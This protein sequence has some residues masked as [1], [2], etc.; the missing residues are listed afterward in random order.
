MLRTNGDADSDTAKMLCREAIEAAGDGILFI[1]DLQW[2]SDRAQ[3]AL[4]ELLP[5]CRGRIISAATADLLLAVERGQ[6]LDR[7]FYRLNILHFR[8]D[9]VSFGE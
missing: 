1:P 7:L 6:F 5:D 3:E 8:L 2:T 9:E 4:L